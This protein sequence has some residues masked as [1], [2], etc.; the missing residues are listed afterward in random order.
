[1]ESHLSLLH[2][3]LNFLVSRTS[4]QKPKSGVYG[5]P[6]LCTPT[7]DGFFCLLE[8]FPGWCSR[9]QL[10]TTQLKLHRLRFSTLLPMK[11][12]AVVDRLVCPKAYD[13]TSQTTPS[14]HA[15]RLGRAQTHV[16]EQPR[17]AAALPWWTDDRHT[18]TFVERLKVVICIF[19][20]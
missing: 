6:R 2:G 3:R 1:L 11:S 7:V 4:Y 20:H 8:P 9:R 19:V 18:W 5:F 15:L 12:L 13:S 17:N 16:A 10:A 14:R